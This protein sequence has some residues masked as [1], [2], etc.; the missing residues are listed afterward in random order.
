MLVVCVWL[1]VV[2][3]AKDIVCQIV[4]LPFVLT[5]SCKP[6]E[7]ACSLHHDG[8]GDLL[9]SSDQWIKFCQGR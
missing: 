2:T 7:K 1:F 8:V 6:V 4:V 5:F 9:A 3:E